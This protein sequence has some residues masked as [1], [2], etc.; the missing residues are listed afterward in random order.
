MRAHLLVL[1]AAVILNLFVGTAAGQPPGEGKKPKGPPDEEK[2]ILKQIEEA[3]K[4][5]FEVYDD[6]RKELR[7][8]VQEPSAER[9]A[10]VFKEIRRLFLPTPEQE[11][12]ILREIRL[13][14]QQPSAEQEQRILRAI[15]RA[16]RLPLGV[17]PPSVQ[18]SQAEK[19]F[20]K[21]EVSGDG[22]LS[23][24]ELPDALRSERARWD[25]NRDGYIDSDEYWAYYQG[26]LQLLSEGVASGQ[27]Q[28][29]PGLVPLSPDRAPA[30][31]E[32]P[33]PAVNRAGQ[34]P[35]GLRDWFMK[36]DA[37]GDG[38]LGLY[39]WKRSGQPL[40]QFAALDRNDDGFVTIAELMR[41]L[42]E[43]AR[44]RPEGASSLPPRR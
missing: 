25:A 5:P 35:P 22:L 39:E 24:A 10:K 43:Q 6:V 36:T 26:R 41:Y 17:V 13:A 19:L 14:Y 2:E 16:D 34:L 4:A 18:A 15:D 7:K 8:A 32:A 3:Y 29:K 30:A 9:E 38:Q 1:V 42:A 28:L 40:E 23:P 20:R 21:L 11:A 12:A 44:D 37:D 31:R 27:I 33:R